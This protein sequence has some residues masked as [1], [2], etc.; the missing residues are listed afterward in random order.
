MT[1][2]LCLEARLPFSKFRKRIGGMLKAI[3][4]QR[5]EGFNL[6]D[7]FQPGRQSMSVDFAPIFHRISKLYGDHER[8]I[9]HLKYRIVLRQDEIDNE[10]QLA[11]GART[12]NIARRKLLLQCYKPR[13]LEFV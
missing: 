5:K 8:D 1:E 3:R 9:E 7:S 10:S 13:R 4:R 12:G 6:T 11:N 2:F